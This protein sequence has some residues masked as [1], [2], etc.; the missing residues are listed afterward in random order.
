MNVL[1]PL[2]RLHCRTNPIRCWLFDNDRDETFE[3]KFQ[4]RA[5]D[6]GL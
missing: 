2:L 5:A 1:P 3:V 4:G 6:L